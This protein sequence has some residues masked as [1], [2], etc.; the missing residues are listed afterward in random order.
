MSATHSWVCFLLWI[1]FS[2]Q[3]KTPDVSVTCFVSE[4]C[5][6]PCSFPPDGEVAIEWFRQDV[7]VYKFTKDDDDDD[8]E[9]GGDGDGEDG[10]D[11]DSE[12][13]DDDSSEELEQLDGRISVF[14][15]L[16][17]HGNATL[18]IRGSASRTGAPTGVT[19]KRRRRTPR[20][21]H[22]EGRSTHPRLVP[23][24]VEDEWLR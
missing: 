9:D 15:D 16:V 14:P 20:E 7:E 11:S 22:P 5:L 21:S 3:H 4:D 24:A 19:L 13:N 6:L 10:E 12:E 23:G 18:V 1:S 17:S 2:S 8:D